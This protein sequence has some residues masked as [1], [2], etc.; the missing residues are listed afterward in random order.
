MLKLR[1]IREAAQRLIEKGVHKEKRL[2]LYQT[3]YVRYSHDI[4]ADMATTFGEM[5][6]LSDEELR[7]FIRV[8]DD[9]L[10]GYFMMQE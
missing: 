4:N 7:R 2:S 10:E 6:R 8:A 3:T 9:D 5:V 1:L